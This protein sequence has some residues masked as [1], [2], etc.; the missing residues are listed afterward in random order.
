MQAP[1]SAALFDQSAGAGWWAVQQV[2]GGVVG[3]GFAL[4]VQAVLAS[5]DSAISIIGFVGAS[6]L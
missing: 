2:G 3:E 6:C 5:D 4:A 1:F